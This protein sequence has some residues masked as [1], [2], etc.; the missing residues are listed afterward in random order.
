MSIHTKN[1]RIAFFISP[2]GFGHA[3]R[4]TAIM[5]AM[6]DS[7]PSVFFEIITSVPEWFFCNSEISDFSYYSLKTDI[8]MIQTSPFHEDLNGTLNELNSFLPFKRSVIEKLSEKLCR[9]NCEL[10]ICDIAPLG[11]EVAKKSGIPSILIENFT[12]DWIYY[13]YTSF[14]S[15][16]KKHIRYLE[17]IFKGADYHIQTKPVC[18]KQ[19]SDLITNPVSRKIRTSSDKIRIKL[20]IPENRKIITITMGGVPEKQC[21]YE[22]LRKHKEVQF[23][24]PGGSNQYELIDNIILLPAKNDFFH[25]DLINASD[26]VIGKAGY[27]TLSEIYYAGTPFG[28]IS[29]PS[30]RESS[31]L[32]SFIDNNMQGIPISGKEYYENTWIT[33]IHELLSLK[34]IKKDCINGADQASEFILQVFMR[35]QLKS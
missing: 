4:A 30:F 12:W 35:N 21:F 7:D 25:P 15:D 6:L 11:L 18:F 23:V 14:H 10:I 24:I 29:R 20:K 22:H 17:N 31:S 19:T 5:K 16:F 3:S 34:K 1:K 28:Y 13:N 8:G 33:R 27:S 9:L 2:H 32:S 26:A